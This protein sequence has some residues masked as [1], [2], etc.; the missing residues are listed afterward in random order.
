MSLLFES[1]AC[2]DGELQ[3]LSY[4]QERVNRSRKALFSA[5]DILALDDILIPPFTHHGL[6]KCRVSYA[7]SLTSINFK[8]YQPMNPKT[9]KVVEAEINYPYKTEDRRQLDQLYEQRGKADDVII[10]VNK[11]LTDSSYGNLLFFDG[12]QWVTPAKPLL[13]GT[14][15]A[16]LV[17]SGL[18]RET[19]VSR[20]ELNRYDR[21][22]MV[23]A[24][25]PFREE[26]AL[27]ISNII[28]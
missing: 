11:Q 16:Q 10:L 21:F 6:W 25:N 17:K 14:M 18:V 26:R 12:K 22:M 27:P 1:I 7:R 19:S 2:L 3:N 5:T 20:Q 13:E 15:R 28:L 8:K 9:F 23:N 24:L 4:H